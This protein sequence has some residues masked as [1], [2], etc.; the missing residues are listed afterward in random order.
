[1]PHDDISR[2]LLDQTGAAVGLGAA[3]TCDAD[4]GPGPTMPLGNLGFAT[5]G[6]GRQPQA[7][8]PVGQ[9]AGSPGERGQRNETFVV[10]R[11]PRVIALGRSRASIVA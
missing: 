4:R 10:A 9:P 1:M 8:S 5:S 2:G 6:R 3:E 7:W 11:T